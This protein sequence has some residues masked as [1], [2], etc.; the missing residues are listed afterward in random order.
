MRTREIQARALQWLEEYEHK[1]W[2]INQ[3]RKE[4]RK[5]VNKYKIFI[6]W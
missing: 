6:G 3:V 2:K 4:R 5:E 1:G